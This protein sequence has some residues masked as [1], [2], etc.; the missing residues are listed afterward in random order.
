MKIAFL[1]PGQGSQKIGMGK[2]LYEKYEDI[3][4]I[5]IRAS[6]LTGID[7]AKLCFEGEELN[8]TENTQIAIATMS[9]A[10]LSILIKNGIRAD[11]AVG[12]S[13]GE[14]PALIYGGQ[15]K[16]EDGLKLLKQRGYLMQHKLPKGEYSM[17]AIIGLESSKIEEICNTLRN[18]GMFIYPANYN[19][20]N[21]TVVSGSQKAIEIASEIFKQNGAK[22]VV[23]L[24]TS[25]PFH[26]KALEDAKNEYIKDLEKIKFEKG[27]TKVIK[28]IDGTF[29]ND[30]DDMV[31]ILSNHIISPVRFDKAIKLMKDENIDTFVEIGPGKTLTGFIKK[32]LEDV[33]VFNIYDVD[34]LENAIQKLTDIKN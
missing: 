15:L 34:T 25:G 9:L 20:S 28:N 7:I 12:L 3:K 13:L 33:N 4:K 10:I 1:F 27:T 8:K 26:T 18:K 11:I 31:E 16:F 22:K 5:Y 23:I 29:Y 21:Q 14:Y 17:L 19:Y 32:E 24:K 2:D 6:E 30:T